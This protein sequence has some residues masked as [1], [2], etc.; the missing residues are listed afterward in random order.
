MEAPEFVIF[1]YDS[2]MSRF[3]AYRTWKDASVLTGFSVVV[4]LVVELPI[5]PILFG[6]AR[7]DIATTTTRATTAESRTQSFICNLLLVACAYALLTD[8]AAANAGL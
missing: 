8:V 5:A 2:P 6:A 4:E 1:T 7:A 3:E